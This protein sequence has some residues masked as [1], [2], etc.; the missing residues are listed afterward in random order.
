VYSKQALAITN[1]LLPEIGRP[2]AETG[3][4]RGCGYLTE[5][6]AAT[7]RRKPP[8]PSR[9]KKTWAIAR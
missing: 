9:W 5:T 3:Y 2:V 7:G 6:R 8:D 4:H 1:P